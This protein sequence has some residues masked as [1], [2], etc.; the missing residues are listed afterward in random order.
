MS[1]EKYKK[2][3]AQERQIHN[4]TGRYLGNWVYG[5]LDGVVTTFAIVAGS[6]GASLSLNIILILGLANLIADG[7]SMAASS[8]LATKTERDFYRKEMERELWEMENMPDAEIEEIREIYEEK[9]FKGKDLDRAVEIITSDKEVWLKTM[10]VEELNLFLDVRTPIRTGLVTFL[11]FVTMGALPL[12]IYFMSATFLVGDSVMVATI[13]LI[14]AT[15]F[16]I[17]SSRSLLISQKWYIS[18]FEMLILG[19]V[20]S[21]VA[22][23]IGFYLKMILG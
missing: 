8:Y 10:M 17:G 14:S 18:G 20:A 12:F 6:L 19:G 16:I 2:H 23:F 1:Q 9:G 5:S 3:Q 11:A 7:I 15:F 22:Y 21:S 4:F 13:A